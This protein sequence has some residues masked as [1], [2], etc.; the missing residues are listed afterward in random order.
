MGLSIGPIRQE[1][2]TYDFEKGLGGT[3]IYCVTSFHKSRFIF[4]NL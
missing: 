3:K 4:R 2:D 1:I